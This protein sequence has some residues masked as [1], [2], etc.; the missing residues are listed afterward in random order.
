MKNGTPRTIANPARRR[1]SIA[2]LPAHVREAVDAAIA[3]GATIDE[4]AARIRAEGGACS[5]A[6]VGR[7]VKAARGPIRARQQTGR[8]VETPAPMPGV[9]AEGGAALRAIEALR[10]TT[11][12]TIGA[13]GRSGKPVPAAELARLALVLK[14]IEE[15]DALRLRRERAWRG[16]GPGLS[17]E[18]VAAIK[19]EWALALGSPRPAPMPAA[20]FGF[21]TAA[22]RA[23]MSRFEPV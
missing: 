5:R 8:E 16:P 23:A 10:A 20:R 4:V 9:R 18:A 12:S 22:R 13:L 15:A 11:L 1:S 21:P 19:D 7:Y 3:D 6:A 17:P 14:R 2:R